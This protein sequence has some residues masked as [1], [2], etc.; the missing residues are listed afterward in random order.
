VTLLYFVTVEPRTGLL[1]RLTMVPMQRQRLRL[2]RAPAAAVHWLR[3][4][5]HREGCT[6]GTRVLMHEDQT[7]TLHWRSDNG[8]LSPSAP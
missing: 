6:F 7:M 4:M 8:D 3:D 2:T 1:Q 5:L